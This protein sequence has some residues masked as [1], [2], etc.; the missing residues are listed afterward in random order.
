MEHISRGFEWVAVAV[1]VL[2]IVISVVVIVRHVTRQGSFEGAY[3][4]G[5]DVFARGILI[6]LEILVAA[7]LIRT[8]AVE[9]T[10]ANVGVLGIIVVVRTILSF[11]LEIE[12][13]GVLPWRKRET[14][15]PET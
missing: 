4:Q 14:R 15:G 5:R 7:D 1:L 6:S 8:V 2:A 13:D 9:P 11:S 10:L 12:M 3:K